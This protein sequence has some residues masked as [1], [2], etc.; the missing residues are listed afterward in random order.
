MADHATT[1]DTTPHPAPKPGGAW[2]VACVCGWEKHGHYA[3]TNRVAEAV[4]LQLAH[5][6]GNRHEGEFNN[7]RT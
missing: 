2:F 4:A 6:Y 1:A 3:R 5:L 7:V